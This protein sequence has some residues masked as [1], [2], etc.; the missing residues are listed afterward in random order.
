MQ[1]RSW[2]SEKEKMLTPGWM[3]SDYRDGRP[4]EGLLDSTR[5]CKFSPAL[6]VPKGRRAGQLGCV[7]LWVPEKREKSSLQASALCWVSSWES[8]YIPTLPQ[9]PIHGH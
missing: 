4:A 7:E 8:A 3:P 5:L 6:C 2:G 9:Y 1:D